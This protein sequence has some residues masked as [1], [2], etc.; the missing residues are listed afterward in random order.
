MASPLDIV[1]SYLAGKQLRQ[2][3][4]SAMAQAAQQQRKQQVEEAQRMITLGKDVY[5]LSPEIGRNLAS[6]GASALLGRE[7]SIPHDAISTKDYYGQANNIIDL[8]HAGQIGDEDVKRH[9]ENL[10][11]TISLK[12]GADAPRQLQRIAGSL[13]GKLQGPLSELGGTQR[14]TL[15]GLIPQI[16]YGVADKYKKER[17]EDLRGQLEASYLDPN[18]DEA[19]R[20]AIKSA[21]YE[22]GK[23]KASEL[24][25]ASGES[26]EPVKLLN[27]VS[28]AFF[29]RGFNA[30]SQGE[31]KQALSEYAKVQGVVSGEKTTGAREADLD[32]PLGREAMYY[33]DPK[34]LA[35][36]KP[37]VSKRQAQRMGAVIATADEIKSIN[38]IDQTK[39][40]LVQIQE[41]AKR[42]IT[43]TNK[44]EAAAQLAYSK[45]PTFMQDAQNKRFLETQDAY[46]GNVAR[47]LGGERGVLTDQDLQRQRSGLPRPGDTIAVRNAKI[48]MQNEFLNVA[49]SAAK[50]KLLGQEFN[51]L[52]YRKKVNKILDKM[53]RVSS[54]NNVSDT[55]PNVGR[56]KM[57]FNPATGVFE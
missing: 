8:Y 4:E 48:E 32:Q 1:Q 42:V 15:E 19:S 27:D 31:K 29:G 53:D 6:K 36:I 16:D 55:A 5:D 26:G 20:T 17:E 46:L 40:I 24:A 21:Y 22:L 41:G 2:N 10:V 44:T 23:G 52:E 28:Q 7:V 37:N 50:A 39:G 34:T 56:N 12:G 25:K 3:E 35:R 11:S 49:Q 51:E 13:S 18:I 14:S 57:T 33:F 54:R 47:T 43:A 30:L 45:L 38:D 9:M